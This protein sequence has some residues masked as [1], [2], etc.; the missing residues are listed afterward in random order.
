MNATIG[1]ETIEPDRVQLR[2]LPVRVTVF[3]LAISAFVFALTPGGVHQQQVAHIGA[4][5]QEE[6]RH[7]AE[8]RKKGVRQSSNRTSHHALLSNSGHAVVTNAYGIAISARLNAASPPAIN[9]A[10]FFIVVLLLISLD[11]ANVKPSTAG[12]PLE[13]RR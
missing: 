10:F 6:H 5:D 1:E 7:G 4:R 9:R 8:Q 11:A 3:L 2:G 12:R 13:F